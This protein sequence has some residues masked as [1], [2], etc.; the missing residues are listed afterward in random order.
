MG[1]SRGKS[2]VRR[3]KRKWEDN[4]KMDLEGKGW[5][6]MGLIDLVQDKDW[7]RAPVNKVMNLRV[8]ENVKI[9]LSSCATG[10]FSRKSLLH[11]IS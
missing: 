10:G 4:I 5:S 8:L 7:W 3:H 11:G 9:F 6:D 1:K 2:A